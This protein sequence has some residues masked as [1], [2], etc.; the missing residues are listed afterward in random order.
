MKNKFPKINV[1]KSSLNITKDQ[2]IEM[3]KQ[4]FWDNPNL[5]E[6]KRVFRSLAKQ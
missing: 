2:I 1:T 6:I 5:E 3:S 4:N